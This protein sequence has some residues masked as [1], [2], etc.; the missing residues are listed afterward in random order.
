MLARKFGDVAL[1]V[2]RAD[3]MKRAFVRSLEHGPKG[4]DAVCVRH[5]VDVL[6]DAVLHALMRVRYP[7]VG[8]R[9]IGVDHGVRPGVLGYEI[10]QRALS[11][12]SITR[13][14]ILLVARSFAPTTA[15]MSTGPRPVAVLRLAF[16]IFLRFPPT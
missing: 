9:V 13:A 16:D 2:F 11:V 5:A 3:F 12:L 7:F 4:L 6:A 14:L 10:L 15:T 1:Q 8:R